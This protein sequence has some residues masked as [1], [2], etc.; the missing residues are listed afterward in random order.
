MSNHGDLSE[1]VRLLLRRHMRF[2]EKK[3]F[4]G[5]SFLLNGNMCCGVHKGELIV[6]FNPG[7]TDSCLALSHTRIFNLSG[8]PMR[9]WILAGPAGLVDEEALT[10]WIRIA[11]DY[12]AS[13]PPK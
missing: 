12:A 3:M 4:G 9:G 2:S 11:E 10:C 1:R 7:S 8:R 5:L 13:F 6:R